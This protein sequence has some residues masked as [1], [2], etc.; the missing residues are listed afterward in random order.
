MRDRTIDTNGGV[1]DVAPGA[2]FCVRGSPDAISVAPDGRC[3]VCDDSAPARISV[4]SCGQCVTYGSSAPGHI[5]VAA[6]GSCCVYDSSAP[7]RIDVAAGGFVYWRSS[8]PSEGRIVYAA[9]K[10]RC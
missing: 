5:D 3:F 1:I 4:A 10:G 6:G 7:G 8:V 9:Q 2:T